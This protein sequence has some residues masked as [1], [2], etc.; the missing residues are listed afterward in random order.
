M[1]GQ[2]IS[3]YRI[4]ERLGGGGMGVVY[5]AEDLNLG[6]HVALKFLPPDLAKNPDALQR[7]KQEARAA[8]SLN[9]PNI[10]TIYE[11]GEAEGEYF[12]AMELLEG[13]PLDKHIARSPL[14]PQEFLALAI[15]IADGLDAAHSKGIIHRD[16]K[17]AN[18]FVTARDQIKILDFGLAKLAAEGKLMAQDA[19]ATAKPT[20]TQLTS[21][22]TVVG[23]VAYMSPEQARGKELDARTDLFSFG[24]VLYQMATGRGPFEGETSAVIFEAILNREPVSPLQLNS[25]LPPKVDEIIGTA[26][27]K[28]RDL[29]YQSAAEIR[30]ELKRLKRKTESGRAAPTT[31]RAAGATTTRTP[32]PVGRGP[33]VANRWLW[34]ISALCVIALAGVLTWIVRG[35]SPI[36]PPELKQRQ[37]TSNSVGNAVASGAISPDGKY[38]AYVDS[39]GVHVQLIANGDTQTVSQPDSLDANAAWSIASWFPDGTSFLTNAAVPGGSTSI[40]MVSLLGRAPRKI[41]DDA[42]AWSVSPDGSQIAFTTIPG[43]FGSREIWVMTKEGEQARKLYAATDENSGF[44][45]VAWSPDG[46]RVGYL[47]FHQMTRYEVS[48]ETRDL[49]GG[50]PTVLLTNFLLHDF[51]WLPDGRV[52]YSLGENRATASDNCNLWEVRVNAATG[53]PVEQPRR[54][55]NW[56]GFNLDHLSATSDGK[57][58]F[59]KSTTHFNVYIGELQNGNTKLTPPRKLTLNE[60]INTPTDWTS[61]SK[62][63]VFESDRNGHWGIYKQ[64]LNRDS[65][66]TLVTSDSPLAARTSPDG[67]WILYNSTPNDNVNSPN[68]SSS[69]PLRLM[70]IP[71]TGGPPELVLT[72]RMNNVWCARS[73]STLC[74]FA[75]QTPDRKEIVFTAFDPIRGKGHELARFATDP[76][77]DYVGW[78]LSPYGTRIAI[79]KTGGNHVYM[80]PLD[81]ST[82]RDLTVAG[83]SGFNTFCWSVDSKGF[84]IGN[85]RGEGLDSNL[86]FVDL[87]GKPH[88]LWHQKSAPFTWGVPSWDGRHLAVLGAEFNGNMWMIESF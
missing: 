27:E 6:R 12:I 67:K 68:S 35:R 63:V 75:D 24:A 1:I 26:M 57:V 87:N 10:C 7:F 73:P 59:Q 55:T 80:I 15:Q 50:S 14:E 41:R 25:E 56:A 77:A 30:A 83:W 18:I 33:F 51:Y 78:S 39:L 21:P 44:T 38:L 74:A 19:D 88:P 47:K 76:N 5:K 46:K 48:I 69:T 4:I 49:T 72:D 22:G 86:L 45:R 3:H 70:R 32:Q 31:A 28:D 8:S 64:E 60:G 16:I 29:R 11:I 62:A 42:T 53:A 34:A 82:V 54:L 84:F 43:L 23:T 52:V 17:P 85:T 66:E 13:K 65:A 20:A 37:L 79:I 2:T 61:D 40:W 9:H 81:G 58:V 71:V 36:A